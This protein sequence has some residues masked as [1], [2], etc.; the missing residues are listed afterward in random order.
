MIAL[1]YSQLFLRGANE[2][3]S[4]P[5]EYGPMQQQAGF[6][7]EEWNLLVQDECWSR[8]QQRKMAS[9][10]SNAV[11]ITLNIAGL[12]AVPLTG[13]Y[14]ASIICKL[15][16][17]CNRIVAASCAPESFDAM[18][19]TGIVCQSEVKPTTREQMVA[20]V[21][22]FTAM[23]TEALGHFPVDGITENQVIEEQIDA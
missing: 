8:A 19:A 10:V 17:P 11:S 9:I 15:V 14:V 23:G 18:S 12:P 13:A 21:C 1:T 20:L 16:A 7:S 6:N 5:R 22:Y 2:L 3:A 4:A